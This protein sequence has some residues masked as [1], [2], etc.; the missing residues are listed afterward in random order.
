M[1]LDNKIGRLKQTKKEHKGPKN[2]YHIDRKPFDIVQKSLVPRS[3][4][5]NNI[6]ST[7]GMCTS[8]LLIGQAHANGESF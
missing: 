5:G 6:I 4:D 2:Y 1:Y 8:C 7:T 3:T